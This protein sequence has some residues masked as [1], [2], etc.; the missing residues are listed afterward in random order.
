[1]MNVWV[2]DLILESNENDASTRHDASTLQ[3][4]W[5]PRCGWSHESRDGNQ[6][7]HHISHRH[8]SAC[9]C[10]SPCCD[11]ECVAVAQER[12]VHHKQRF[13]PLLKS[14]LNMIVL[15]PLPIQQIFVLLCPSNEVWRVGRS[16]LI[17][18]SGAFAFLPFDGLLLLF[19]DLLQT[20]KFFSLT[21]V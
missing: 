15:S 11:E 9:T 10:A 16:I 20:E 8:R 1:M 12:C 13:S 17:F 19:L 5:K 3:G 6:S 21:L 18:V 14:S 2:V 7:L 4:Y